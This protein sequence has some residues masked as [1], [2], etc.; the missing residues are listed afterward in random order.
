MPKFNVH[1]YRE[2]RLYYPDIEAASPEAA[3][4]IADDK[5][6][7]DAALIED[8]DSATLSALVDL[9]GDAEYLQSRMIDLQPVLTLAHELLACLKECIDFDQRDIPRSLTTC[10]H[11]GTDHG[12][13]ALALGGFCPADYCPGHKARAVITKAEPHPNKDKPC[14]SPYTLAPASTVNN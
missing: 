14:G 7:E 8:C 5:R 2:M 4:K 6:P 1:L 9:Q 11:C 10:R 13:R 3:T 12:D